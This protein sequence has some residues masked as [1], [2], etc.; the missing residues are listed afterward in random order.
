MEDTE[1]RNFPRWTKFCVCLCFIFF[2]VPSSWYDFSVDFLIDLRNVR[3]NAIILF[4]LLR[5]FMYLLSCKISFGIIGNLH[6]N[7]QQKEERQTEYFSA[8]NTHNHKNAWNS[9]Q[10]TCYLFK[11]PNISFLNRES[12]RKEAK[13]TMISCSWS[14]LERLLLCL[15][16]DWVT[17][18]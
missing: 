1:K 16:Y 10:N 7:T 17:S 14:L 18:I 11:Y 8:D 15:N 6:T 3:A 2:T 13:D 4:E 12:K 9:T 5:I